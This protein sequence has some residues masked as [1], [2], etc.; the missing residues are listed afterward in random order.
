MLLTAL[1]SAA[2]S[3]TVDRDGVTGINKTFSAQTLHHG[4]LAI[5]VHTHVVDDA[6][7][8]ENARITRDGTVSDITDYLTLSTSIFLGLGLGPYTDIGLA[9]PLYYEKFSS[10]NP[11]LDMNEQYQGDL[12]YRLKVQFPFK[13]VQVVDLALILGGTVPTQPDQRGV[14]PRELELM[15]NDPSAFNE[16]SSPFGAGRPTFMAGLGLTMDLGQVAEKFQFLWHFNL[17]V[18]KTNISSKP[19][20]QDILFWSTAAEYEPGSFIRF[21]AEFYHEARFDYLGNNEFGTDPTTLTFGAVAQTPVGVDFY[22][23]LVMGMNDDYIPVS[24]NFEGGKRHE[25]AMKGSPDLSMMFEVTWNGFVLKQDNDNDGIPNKE[26]KCPND[27]ED[28]D[29]FQDEDGCPD[30]DNDKD[31][32]A[33]V[34]DKCPLDAEDKDGF[35]D[36]DGCPEPDNDKDGIPD[37]KDRCPNDAQ[38]ADGKDGCPNLDKDNDGVADLADKCPNEPEDRDGFEDDDGCPDPDNDKDGIPD[39]ADKCPGA[40]ET[41][42][43]FEDTDGCPD[44]LEVK[45]VVKTMVLKGVNFK[46]GSSEL[47]A[48]SYRVL[49][50]VLSQI[51]ANKD[52]QFEVAGHTDNRGN[53]TKNQMLSQ[54][55]AQTVA[56]YFISK[57][58]DAS[59]LKVIG[60]GSSRPLGPNTTAEGRALNRRVEL[61][62][63]N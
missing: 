9:L 54:A 19:P 51:Q 34:Q 24:Y 14:I 35:Q 17:G 47:T 56:N 32:I 1:A 60:Y 62:R 15:T 8:L 58:V 7:I 18:R 36:N 31:G 38:G 44:K 3:T 6:E 20:F 10:D 63:L 2:W 26:D 49:D 25:F 45:E 33:D 5:G 11:G 53:A 4:K 39:V 50:D 40:A 28:K 16:G 27:P 37:L 21:F 12:R 23:G 13:D 52:I 48:E 55:R 61:N 30:P 41:M 43:G 42:N 22:A 46:T 57:G 59:R 29:G